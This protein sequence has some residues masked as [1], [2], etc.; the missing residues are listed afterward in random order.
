MPVF[1]T[2][3]MLNFILFSVK[4]YIGLSANSISIYSDGINNLFD[5]ISCVAAMLCFYFIN[6]GRDRFSH[7]LMKKTE[8]LVSLALSLII[9]AVGTV[10]FYNSVERLMYPTP[11][12][13]AVNYFYVLL[14]TAAVKLLMFF[15]LRYKAARL[16]SNTIRLMSVD[17]LT[18][19]FITAVTVLTL[20]ISQKGS[21]SFDAFGGIII[22]IFIVVTAVKN[23]CQSVASMLG[24]E[25]KEKR[26]RLEQL[27][28]EFVGCD[29][30]EAEL[31]FLSEKRVY[32]KA[33]KKIDDSG[34]EELKKKVYN[35]TGIRL[36]I[37]K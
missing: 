30:Y 33:E 1:V 37:I 16:D 7:A 29:S 5:G 31:S 6:K 19:F 3:S 23:I 13:F 11:V 15:Y 18:D 10:F 21:Y 27:L 35:E 36:Y 9:F 14:I 32:L 2:A 20:F 8:Q 12:W 25:K 34:L 4:L 22:S 17:S 24:I 26:E 28:D